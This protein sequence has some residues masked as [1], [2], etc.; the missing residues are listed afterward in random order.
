[1]VIA[2]NQL[3]H[4]WV[5]A[6]LGAHA[7]LELRG[8]VY[9]AKRERPRSASE[10]DDELIRSHLDARD[11]A[12]RAF[13]GAAR[14]WDELGVPTLQAAHGTTNTADVARWVESRRPS[15]LVLFGCSIIK[16]PLLETYADKVVNMHL[17]LS[18]YYRGAATNFWPLVNGEPECVGATIH[19][20]TLIVDAGPVLRQV[21]PDIAPADGPHEIGCRTIVAGATA[22]GDAVA[23]YGAGELAGVQQQDG[24]RLYRNADFGADAIRELRRRLEAGMVAEYLAHRERRDAAFPIVD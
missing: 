10:S 14:D 5:A 23:R 15:H 9:E 3:R 16:R 17:G 1:V 20:A 19:V 11:E 7:Q 22:L 2:G 6:N 8:V 4:R 24:G 13:F 21:R 12:E 18:P